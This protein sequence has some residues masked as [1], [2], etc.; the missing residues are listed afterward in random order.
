MGEVVRGK[1]NIFTQGFVRCSFGCFAN[2][3][4]TGP[5]KIFKLLKADCKCKKKKKFKRKVYKPLSLYT[6]SFQCYPN[7]L[8]TLSH[9]R[10]QI[11]CVPSVSKM[12]WISVKKGN[13]KLLIRS[14]AVKL[15][16]STAINS[17]VMFF[18]VFCLF[19]SVW[20]SSL[21]IIWLG[22]SQRH[23]GTAV[24]ALHCRYCRERVA[25]SLPEHYLFLASAAFY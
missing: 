22:Q 17:V 2:S 15:T 25:L 9:T 10:P 23:R 20:Y 4:K 11:V 12:W 24:S 14:L 13:Q 8:C 7:D 16:T 18:E 19:V 3:A 1:Q 6:I 21:C 5:W